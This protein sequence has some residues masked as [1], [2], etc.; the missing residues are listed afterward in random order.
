MIL[1][2]A[3]ML[4]ICLDGWVNGGWGE[5]LSGWVDELSGSVCLFVRWSVLFG[6][7][8]YPGRCF[9]LLRGRATWSVTLA[10]LRLLNPPL[11][12]FS[13]CSNSVFLQSVYVCDVLMTGWSDER[14]I[15]LV[16]GNCIIGRTLGIKMKGSVSMGLFNSTLTTS[17]TVPFSVQNEQPPS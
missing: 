13:A 8:L 7:P 12:F 15:G 10:F 1:G 17:T 3:S 14:R 4:A 16:D 6:K 11:D 9:K 2:A 5:S